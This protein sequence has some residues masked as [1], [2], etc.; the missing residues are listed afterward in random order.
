MLSYIA[1]FEYRIILIV[2]TGHCPV[3]MS[4]CIVCLRVSFYIL[5][6]VICDFISYSCVNIL[7][8]PI[9]K[10]SLQTPAS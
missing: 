6:C 5:S 10:F 4:E 7:S 9:W 8:L 1:S 3:S 2:V